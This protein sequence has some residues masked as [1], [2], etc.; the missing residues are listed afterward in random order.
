MK[1]EANK[2]NKESIKK[3]KRERTKLP[4]RLINIGLNQTVIF[5]VIFVCT[6]AT[7]LYNIHFLRAE[8]KGGF[9]CKQLYNHLV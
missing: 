9:I 4:C 5:A 6:V 3:K 2:I 1:I 8:M 7:N